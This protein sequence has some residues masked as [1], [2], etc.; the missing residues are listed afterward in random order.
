MVLDSTC[1]KE[2]SI[3]FDKMERAVDPRIVHV[4]F[5]A[6][7]V[8]MIEELAFKQWPRSMVVIETLVTNH[9]GVDEMMTRGV[10][11][12]SPSNAF[13]ER[14]ESKLRAEAARKRVRRLQEGEA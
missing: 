8:D 7:S 11:N 9:I 6:L 12:N 13:Q 10:P 5:G 3:A 14:A 1:S 4:V 2:E